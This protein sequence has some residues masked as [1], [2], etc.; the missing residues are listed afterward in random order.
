M[1]YGEQ[2]ERFAGTSLVADIN[3]GAGNSSPSELVEFNGSL[4]FA[5]NDG[6]RGEE[7]WISDGTGAGTT[8]VR[9]IYP[10]EDNGPLQSSPREL[11]EVDGQV[12][13]QAESVDGV[14]LWMTDGTET[15]T[16]QVLDIASVGSSTPTNLVA[17]SGQ[18]LLYC[19]RRYKRA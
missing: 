8:I 17:V 10:G 3:S 4:L 11:V 5:A 6:V 13:F 1:S 16:Q 15:G 2:T 19:R 9:D 14:E 18:T 12:F 7:L